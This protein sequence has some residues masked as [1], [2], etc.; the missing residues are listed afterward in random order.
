MA[1]LEQ[2]PRP[3]PNAFNFAASPFDCLTPDEQALVRDGVDIAYFP[4]G[5]VVL[6]AGSAPTHLFVI[7]KGHVVQ[8]EGDEVL[9]S[10][11]PDDSFDGRALVAGRTGSRFTV[12]EELIA[13]QLARETVGELI[14]RNTA[15]GA[16]LFSDLGHKLGTLA[17][18]ADR[19]E[20]QSLTLARVDQAYLRTAHVVDAATDIVSV[21]RL[22]HAERTTSVLVSGLPQGGLGIFTGTTLQRAILDGRPLER[23]AVGEFAS[24]PVFTVRADDQL[25]DALVVLLRARVHRLAVLD[26]QGQVLGILEALDLFSFLANHSHLITVQ[27]EQA[28]D[29][30]ALEQAAAQITRLVAALHRGG[31]RIALMA[32]LVQQLNARLFERAWQMLA[33][34]DLVAH[35]CLFVMGSEGRG[36]QLLKTDQDNGLLLRDGY[37]PP[38]DLDAICARFSAQLQRFGYPEC[39]GGIM[40]SN[41]L[42]RGTVADFGRRV[43]EWLI[44]PSPQGLMHLAI[45]LDAH[46]VAGDAALLAQ[47]RRDLMAL[48]LD[49]DAQVARF[50]SA[51]DAFAHEPG[52][53]WERLLGRG[54]EGAPVHLKKAGIFPIV[55]G[56]RSLALA[57]HIAATGTAERLAA[58]VAEGV[59]DEV[60]GRELLEGLHF[61]MGLR[62]QAG[63]A[64]IDLGRPVTGHVDPARL[65]SLER[66]L[67]KDTLAVVR[68][69]RELLRQRLRLDAV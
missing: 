66:D 28:A 35:S 43:R 48:A 19:H 20:L 23:L 46:A 61:L 59:L 4:E 9:A 56:V 60:Q 51:V 37:A 69:F 45:F 67:L 14:A 1:G 24:Q 12:A 21:V 36:E 3:M 16:L 17:Q 65:S 27:I 42:W 33:P 62:L 6:D 15:F 2:R 38:Q 53:W 32:R 49:S 40:L 30:Q 13:Y 44:L 63:L 5:A 29:L 64:E 10:Y 7:I 54:D 18:R 25:G 26:A 68:R 34:P 22:F 55:H 39:P 11:G 50:A 8:T 31:T 52:S 58:L 57:H 47:V 41:P